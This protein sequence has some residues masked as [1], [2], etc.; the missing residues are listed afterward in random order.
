MDFKFSGNK[1]MYNG[2]EMRLK[3]SRT[4][5]REQSDYKILSLA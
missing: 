4:N 2:M 5:R 3:L 1:K